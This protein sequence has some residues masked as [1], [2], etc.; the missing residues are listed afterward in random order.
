MARLLIVALALGALAGCKHSTCSQ[1][2]ARPAL[3]AT[4]APCPTPCPTPC[5]NGAGVLPPPPP[6]GF[7]R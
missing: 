5:P 1:Y 3:V 6:P 7:P 2:S 4:P